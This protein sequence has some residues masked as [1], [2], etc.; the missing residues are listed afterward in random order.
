MRISTRMFRIAVFLAVGNTAFHG[1][2]LAQ[3]QPQSETPPGAQ[4]GQTTLPYAEPEFRG[5]VG[6]TFKDSDPAK[7]PQRVQAPAGAPNIL[8]VLLDDAGFGQ[9]S[10][11]GGGVPSPNM[12]KLAREGLF[13]NRFHTTALC[14]PSRAAL[15]TGRNHHVAGTGIITEL[16]T[17]YDGYTG[18]IPKSTAT[19]AEILRQNGYITAWIGKNHNTPIYETSPM[20][21]FD[22][23][24]NGL[25]F[26]Y[27][28]GFMAGDTNQIRPYIYENQTPVGTPEAKDYFLSTDLANKA[29][30]WLKMTQE[31]QP[32]KPW[33][34][35]LA[36]AATHSPHQAP[37]ELI[38]KYKGKFDMGWDEYRRQ[39][40]ERQK[41]IGVVPQDAILTPRAASLP[42]WDSLNAD[43]KRLYARMMEVFA[44]YGDQVDQEMGRVVD[45]VKSM[46]NADNTLIIYI[47]GDNGASAE[48]GLDGTLNENAFFNAYQMTYKEMLPHIDEIGTEK[49]FNHFPAEW[50]WAMDTPFQWTKQVASHL[51]GTRNP[52]I[53]SWPARIKDTNQIRSQF[54]HIIDV[55]PTILDAAGVAEPRTVNGTAQQP[56]EGRSFLNTLTDKNAKEIRTSQYF[57]IFANRGIYKDGWWA[58]S[59]S[60]EPWQSVRG[61]YD[62]FKAKWE[63]YN[64]DKDFSQGND[65]AAQNPEKLQELVALW[66]A[67]ASRNKVLPLDWRGAER[68]SAEMTGKPNLAGDR[69]KF[70]YWGIFSGLPEASAPDLKNK[71]FTITATVEV[72]DNANGMIFTQGG[73]T[74][75]WAFYLK[76]GK[77]VGAHNYVDVKRFTVRSDSQVSAGKHEVKMAFTYDGGKQPGKSGT[78][79][80]YVD[81]KQVGSGKVEQT[82]PFKYSLSENQD[83]GTDTGTPLSD[84]YV[85]PFTFQ[86]VLEQVV[87]DLNQ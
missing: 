85:E 21:P 53:V 2:A 84:D 26:D 74:G 81:N 67:E 31:V 29:L 13:F 8:L 69:K 68:F 55:A 1:V 63:L 36:P 41:K 3:S 66:W 48:G 27:F 30:A 10:V 64:L 25:G 46:P 19:V 72:K 45:Y 35:Y 33:F 7:F 50:A 59:L 60:F 78:I 58:A 79:T 12:E 70:T 80:L 40:F 51:G 86:G 4:S 83:V 37:A 20:G 16:A 28:Y 23:W 87:V 49:H 42:A 39:T 17:G 15:L 38:A 76:D 5:A 57:E 73:N 54:V 47:V 11:S 71:S 75:G 22:H 32:S 82:T 9:F 43:Q 77:V 56:I 44:A 24:P 14:S 52:M 6:T 34:L 18:I 62:P 65:L 61:E